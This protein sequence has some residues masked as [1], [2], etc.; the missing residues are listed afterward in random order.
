MHQDDRNKPRLS[1]KSSCAVTQSCANKT[2]KLSSR[3]DGH[4]WTTGFWQLWFYGIQ[5][6]WVNMLNSNSFKYFSVLLKEVYCQS[7]PTLID[8]SNIDKMDYCTSFSHTSVFYGSPEISRRNIYDIFKTKQK[9]SMFLF[10]PPPPQTEERDWLGFI[11]S[12]FLI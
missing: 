8:S 12:T 7:R 9:N 11:G 6:H 10:F 3:I 4:I 5:S 1:W 2:L